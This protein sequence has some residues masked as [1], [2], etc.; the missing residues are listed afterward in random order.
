MAA[1]AMRP[2][3]TH[4]FQ[5]QQPSVPFE[6]RSLHQHGPAVVRVM[7]DAELLRGQHGTKRYPMIHFSIRFIC[8]TSFPGP[9]LLRWINTNPSMDK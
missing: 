1:R 3:R 5:L 2:I 8:L 4:Q 9:L 6:Y 7:R